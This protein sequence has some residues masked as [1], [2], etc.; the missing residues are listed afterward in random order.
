MERSK[1]DKRHNTESP[2]IKPRTISAPTSPLISSFRVSPSP[3]TSDSSNRLE[4]VRIIQRTLAYIIN[5]PSSVSDEATL[6]SHLY[7]G[8]Y[9]KILKIHISQG[10]HNNTESTYGA[11]LTYSKE[12]EAAICIRAC[13]DFILEG[14][15][16]SL[17]FGTTKYCSYFL[18]GMKCP[19]IE[20]VFLHNIA[21]KA[22]MLF[23][24][25][26]LTI[27]HIQPTDSVF[28]RLK[29]HI[30]SPIFPSKLPE[31]SISRDRTV[32]EI[33]TIISSPPQRSRIHSNTSTSR[34]PFIIDNDEHSVEIPQFF[35]KLR[36]YASPCKDSAI[37]PSKD[38][39]NLLSPLSPLHWANDI[40]EVTS[41]NETQ[42]S[43]VVT[44][45][46][47]PA[48]YPISL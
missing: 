33:V 47:N 12:E 40:L 37:I 21:P 38:I 7:F 5:L 32:S 45:K 43:T 2:M 6:S 18:K 29:I 30:S 9:G 14:K 16:L 42:N 26:I 48:T 11:Y 34:Y 13:N 36:Q 23:R 24:K 19:K 3:D 35:E 22:D 8:K 10:H 15:K 28:D 1:H 4:D 31:V 25:E 27:K 46:A 41:N 17:T 44:K 20:C 39:E